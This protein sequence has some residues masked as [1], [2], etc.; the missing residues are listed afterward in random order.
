MDFL[1]MSLHITLDIELTV[2]SFDGA[3]K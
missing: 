1:D 3:H 2:A